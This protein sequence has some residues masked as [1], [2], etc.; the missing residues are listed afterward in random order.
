[1]YFM[2][3]IIESK[4]KIKLLPNI[5]TKKTLNISKYWLLRLV[6]SINELELLRNSLIIKFY[7]L[8]HKKSN[9]LSKIALVLFLLIFVVCIYKEVIL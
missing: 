5:K 9:L 8:N 3:F 1:M 2:K 6:Y 7:K 4:E